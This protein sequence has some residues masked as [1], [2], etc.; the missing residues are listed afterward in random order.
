MNF[1]LKSECSLMS[2]L[3]NL[4]NQCDKYKDESVS[5]QSKYK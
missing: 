4:Q 3:A 5:N 1:Q 2:K